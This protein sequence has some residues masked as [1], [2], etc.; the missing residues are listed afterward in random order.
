MVPTRGLPRC[1]GHCRKG[2]SGVA[3]VALVGVRWLIPRAESNA[4][5]TPDPST[6]D[7]ARAKIEARAK[8]TA[9][10]ANGIATVRRAARNVTSSERTCQVYHSPRFDGGWPRLN[11]PPIVIFV[12]PANSG[13]GLSRR[14]IWSSRRRR[15]PGI[16]AA[17][18]RSQ[19]VRQR[20]LIPPCGGSNPPAPAS[21]SCLWGFISPLA[22]TADISAG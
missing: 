12:Y 21:Q 4:R 13:C 2:R 15:R 8:R 16:K 5:N 10:C 9:R 22:R 20:I 17:L 7:P 18:G 1:R 6:A 3:R 11:C 14:A 19:A